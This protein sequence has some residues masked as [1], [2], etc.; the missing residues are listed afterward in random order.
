MTACVVEL[1]TEKRGLLEMNKKYVAVVNQYYVNQE[2][3]Y[4]EVRLVPEISQ[5][6]VKVL[7]GLEKDH[8]NLIKHCL[9]ME[10]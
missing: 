2:K 9:V 5:E 8:R 10:D 4:K 6:V 7:E 1:E 3:K